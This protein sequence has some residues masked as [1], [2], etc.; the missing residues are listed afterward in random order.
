MPGRQVELRTVQDGRKPSN[1][2]A[3]RVNSGETKNK[4]RQTSSASVPA[5]MD[6]PRR[7]SSSTLSLQGSP[8]TV[9]AF[10]KVCVM[11][12]FFDTTITYIYY[13]F[14]QWKRCL[15]AIQ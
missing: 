4:K 12:V 13:Y 8:F 11:H 6:P 7:S 15:Q 9:H 3:K 10:L 2:R 5:T 1:S 14:P